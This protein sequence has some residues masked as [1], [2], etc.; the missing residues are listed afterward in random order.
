M[1]GAADFLKC[2][3]CG[4]RVDEEPETGEAGTIPAVVRTV[5][6]DRQAE[7]PY[8]PHCGTVL[9]VLPYP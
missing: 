3:N 2:P 7:F 8:C 4:N 5:V 9:G 1:A 6:A